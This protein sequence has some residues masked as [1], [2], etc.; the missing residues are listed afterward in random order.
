MEHGFKS[1]FEKQGKESDD[2]SD[3]MNMQKPFQD[4]FQQIKWLNHYA[5]MNIM[6]IE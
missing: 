4:L 3:A 5:I 2:F 6:S 1:L